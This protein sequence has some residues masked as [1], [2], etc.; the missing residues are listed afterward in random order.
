[1]IIR[2]FAPANISCIFKPIFGNSP[3]ETGSVGLGFTINEGVTVE[4]SES[5]ETEILFNAKKIDFPTVKTVVVNLIDKNVKVNLSSQLS[6]GC[7]F[8]LSSAASLATAFALNKLFELG[9][10]DLDLAKIAHISE[11]VNNT[12][13]GD[14]TNQY[15]GGCILKRVKSSDFIVEK[16]PLVGTTVFCKAYGTLETK[17]VLT[18]GHKMRQI[19]F[20]ADNAMRDLRSEINF[21]QLIE[22]SKKFAIE[23]GLLQDESVIKKIS[24][25]E[26]MGGHA[27]MVMLGKSVFS[28]IDF[29]GAS[30]YFISDRK[31]CL[32]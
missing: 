32:L 14:V 3:A 13:L 18:D 21:A 24:D 9:R 15:F 31:A 19:N 25:I 28:D 26:K 22:S 10:S 23:S 8:G 16:I 17:S 7:G 30:K 20:A 5:F 2:A 4:I 6:L 27:S 12:G 1:M 11:V 29:T